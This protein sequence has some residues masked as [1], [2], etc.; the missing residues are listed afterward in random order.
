MKIFYSLLLIICLTTG[1]NAQT[2]VFVSNPV[3]EQIM[4]GNYN[5]A[6]YQAST[7]ITNHAVISQGLQNDVSPDSLKAIIAKL[8]TFENRNTGSDT[9]SNVYGIGATR[10]W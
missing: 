1:V 10:R 6:N 7:V 9:T 5:P 3:A 2:N 4:L 8:V